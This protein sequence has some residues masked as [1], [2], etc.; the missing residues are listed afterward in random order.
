M[1]GEVIVEKVQEIEQNFCEIIFSSGQELYLL[2]TAHASNESI[3]LVEKVIETYLPSDVCIELDENRLLV[4]KD[5]NALE[6]V[7]IVKLL[8]EKKFLFFFIHLMLSVFQKSM[9]EKINTVLGGEFKKAIELS[10]EKNIRL[11]LVDREANITLRRAWNMMGFWSQIKSFFM[12]LSSEEKDFK[13]EDIEALK[14]QQNLTEMISLM[15]RSFPIFKKALIDERDQYMAKKIMENLGEKTVAIVGAGHVEGIIRRLKSRTY[16][17]I[18]IEE[19]NK[20]P[21]GTKIWKVLAFSFPILITGLFIYGFAYGDRKVAMDALF[22]WVVGHS[23]F[24]GLGALLAMGHPLAVLV[25]ALFSPVTSLNPF[26]GVGLISGITQ[27]YF[28]KPRVKDFRSF[29]KDIKKPIRWWKNKFIRIILV[30]FMSS[31]G[32]SLG[33]IVSLKF[34]YDIL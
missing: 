29:Q 17:Q 24:S 21:S 13:E 9:A 30:F 2:G 7:D 19:L 31:L 3:A 28:S 33:T 6:N 32:S 15:E 25:S 5:E 8:K 1:N 34:L 26:I 11:H 18:D 27:F 4:L 23:F 20:V 12:I 16:S 10:E 14:K 22:A